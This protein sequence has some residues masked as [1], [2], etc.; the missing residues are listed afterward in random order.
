MTGTQAQ[1]KRVFVAVKNTVTVIGGAVISLVCHS[2]LCAAAAMFLQFFF[3][4]L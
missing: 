2:R 3:H 1:T 4:A